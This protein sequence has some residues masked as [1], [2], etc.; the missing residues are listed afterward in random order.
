M[1]RTAVR[2]LLLTASGLLV[3]SAQLASAHPGHDARQWNQ[4]KSAVQTQG[5]E[6]QQQEQQ[7]QQH[8]QQRHLK[9]GHRN[10]EEHQARRL[11][12]LQ[13]A[14]QYFGI[15]TQGKSAKQLHDELKATRASDPAKWDKFKAAHK[16]KRLANL[17]E[18]AEREGISTKGKTARQICDELRK[19]RENGAKNEKK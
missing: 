14:A 4:Q 19:A 1:M 18:A 5:L 16:A 10:S 13:E 7:E 17:Q 12:H 9:R 8:E 3:I 11:K 2:S 6:P 15:S